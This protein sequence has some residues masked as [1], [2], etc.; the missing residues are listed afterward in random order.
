LL[1]DEY[2]DDL[3]RLRH[4]AD[5]D[6]EAT[7]QA[8]QRFPQLGPVGADIFCRAAQ[9][10]RPELR[11]YFDRKALDGAERVD[12]PADPSRLAKLV[13]AQDQT[14]LAA[15]LVLVCLNRSLAGEVR[16]QPD[17]SVVACG[18]QHVRHLATA[19]FLAMS[20]FEVT[21]LRQFHDRTGDSDR[22]SPAGRRRSPFVFSR[23]E[24]SPGSLWTYRSRSTPIS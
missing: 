3:R 9:A 8:L 10:V 16:E 6:V 1:R 17:W 2:R 15:A 13:G 11:P 14:G 24:V 18:T 22:L 20:P 4:E 5:G 12:L 19:F 21:D 23:Q 7:R